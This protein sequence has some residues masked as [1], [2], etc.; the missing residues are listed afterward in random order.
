MNEASIFLKLDF[1]LFFIVVIAS[2]IINI[3]INNKLPDKTKKIHKKI[4]IDTWVKTTLMFSSPIFG[5]ITSIVHGGFEKIITQSFFCMSLFSSFIAAWTIHKTNC[6]LKE[7]ILMKNEGMRMER[8]C[9]VEEKNRRATIIN[10]YC[11]FMGLFGL[12]YM[13]VFFDKHPTLYIAQMSFLS[14]ALAIASSRL[15]DIV[16]LVASKYASDINHGV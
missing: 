16:N 15:S 13:V 7:I 12:I 1:L 9:V 6:L 8:I 5:C 11:F 10:T 3:A 14:T 4:C 2:P